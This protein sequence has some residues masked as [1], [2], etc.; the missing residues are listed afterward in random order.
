MSPCLKYLSIN[1]DSTGTAERKRSREQDQDH[2]CIIVGQTRDTEMRLAVRSAVTTVERWWLT[3]YVRTQYFR[4]SNFKT[5]TIAPI[6]S[7]GQPRS[8]DLKI[9]QHSPTTVVGY[10]C[11]E[12]TWRF[13]LYTV[14]TTAIYRSSPDCVAC[15]STYESLP[16]CFLRCSAL[17][18]LS[19][20]NLNCYYVK[21]TQTKY[22]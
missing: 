20:Y 5:V 21:S 9:D 19:N 7:P 2:Y 12:D 22:K 18:H 8:L 4:Q 15:A 11:D 3:C 13:V 1:N 6:D 16:S 14:Q 17:H 10:I